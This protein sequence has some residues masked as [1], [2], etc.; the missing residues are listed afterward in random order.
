MAKITVWHARKPTWGS[1]DPAF[2]QDNFELVATLEG[3]RP[4]DGYEATNHIDC[5]WWENEGVTLVGE[6]NQRSTSVGDVV[7]V[8]GVAHRCLFAGWSLVSQEAA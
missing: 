6:P 7:V 2:T 5:P 8:D 1:N 4:D 3:E